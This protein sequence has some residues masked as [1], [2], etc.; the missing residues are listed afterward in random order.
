MNTCQ[1]RFVAEASCVY[2][3]KIALALAE[4]EVEHPL[5]VIGTVVGDTNDS[6]LSPEL[7]YVHVC[8]EVLAELFLDSSGYWIRARDAC[9]RRESTS[10][11]G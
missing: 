8:L 11:R 2:S 9:P 7:L 1:E 4:H 5:E 10:I 6:A 3:V